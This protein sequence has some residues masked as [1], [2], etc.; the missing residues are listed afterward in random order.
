MF[1]VGEMMCYVLGVIFS[2]MVNVLNRVLLSVNF[3]GGVLIGIG[4]WKMLIIIGGL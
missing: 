1:F 3:S 4:V 2:D